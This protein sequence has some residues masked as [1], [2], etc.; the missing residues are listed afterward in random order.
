M[1]CFKKK[2]RPKQA[3]LVAHPVTNRTAAAGAASPPGSGLFPPPAPAS[4]SPGP[5]KLFGGAT[6]DLK[7]TVWSQIWIVCVIGKSPAEE[8][9]EIF[10]LTLRESL[11]EAEIFDFGCGKQM[12]SMYFQNMTGG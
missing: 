7:T 11:R 12:L 4:P 5:R 10:E 2:H 9:T 3:V 8:K 1:C 6:S